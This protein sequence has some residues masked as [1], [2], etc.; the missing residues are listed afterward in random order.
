MRR[1]WPQGLTGQLLA[2]LLLALLVGQALSLA[3]FADERRMALRAVNREQV[4]SR[5]ASLVKLLEETPAALHERILDATSSRQLSFRV[6]HASAVD[7]KV[8]HHARNRLAVQLREE[9]GDARPVLVEIRDERQMRNLVGFRPIDDATGRPIYWRERRPSLALLISVALPDG[10]WL[11]AG[12][13][14]PPPPGWALPSLASL[15]LSAAL[16]ALVVILLV[17]RIARPMQQ[18][19]TAADALGRGE[20]TAPLVEAG[21]LEV[22]RTMRAFNRMQARLRRFVDDRTRMLAAISHDLRTPITSLRLRAELVDEDENR[23]RMLATLDE[24]QR[25][26]EASL[27]FARE[28][29]SS[30]TTR[31]VDLSALIESVVSDLADL[32][33]D[34]TFA[35]APRT[36]YPCRP[37]G[38]KRALRNLIENAIAYGGGARVRLERDEEQLRVVVDDVGPGIPPDMLERVFEPFVRLEG[39]R[40]RDTGGIGLGLS[41]A[42]TIARGHGG[43]VVLANRPSGGL[44]ATLLLPLAATSGPTRSRADARALTS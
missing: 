36:P 8:P 20:A 15:G 31:V 16:V 12:T 39:S 6:D 26:V 35:G 23:E 14:F 43:D 28:E 37:A 19:A 10:T 22:R 25:I 18:L 17:R 41:I 40:S 24:M 1:L 2:V 4:L 7:P 11:N 44:A 38:L 27:E 21:P 32:G 3:I 13:G 34:A 33:G 29:A 42:R 9:I 5:T 30:E